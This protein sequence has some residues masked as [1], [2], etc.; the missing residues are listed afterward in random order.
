[1]AQGMPAYRGSPKSGKGA[2]ILNG[3]SLCIKTTTNSHYVSLS[4]L[5]G[6][7][8]CGIVLWRLIFPG[9]KDQDLRIKLWSLDE[10]L[11]LMKSFQLQQ[12]PSSVLL[13]VDGTSGMAGITSHWHRTKVV[14]TW[15]EGS[16]SYPLN[17][18]I[19]QQ[20]CWETPSAPYLEQ[21]IKQTRREGQPTEQM[22]NLVI[23]AIP[24]APSTFQQKKVSVEVE[25]FS[26][27]SS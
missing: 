16:N 20:R 22:L 8:S 17:A 11:K 7:Q 21:S 13:D 1:M 9:N 23:N 27:F 5:F 26:K 12:R 3:W 14:G 24:P 2:Y 4:G 6:K 19:S 25:S 18:A 10:N 15:S